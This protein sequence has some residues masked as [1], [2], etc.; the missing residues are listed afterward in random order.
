VRTHEFPQLICA[1]VR[2]A[3]VS[4]HANNWS[5]DMLQASLFLAETVRLYFV[6]SIQRHWLH[7]STEADR[8]RAMTKSSPIADA[9]R[10]FLQRNSQRD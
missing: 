10:Q 7:V 6:P 8:F 3:G 5:K 4:M 1:P 9:S 2:G